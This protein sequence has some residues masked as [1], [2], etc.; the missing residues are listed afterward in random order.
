MMGDF[1]KAQSIMKTARRRQALFGL[2]L[3]ALLGA[4]ACVDMPVRV[5]YPDL[6]LSQPTEGEVVAGLKEALARGVHSA[7][8]ELGRTNGFYAN[9]LVR[10]A[11]PQDLSR[12]ETTLRQ[13]GQG[14][15]VDEFETTLNRA[16]ERAVPRAADIFADAIRQMSVRDAIDLVQGPDDAATRYFQRTTEARLRAAFRP[17]V[18][19]QTQRVGVT[20]SYKTMLDRAGFLRGFISPE[21]QDLDGYVTQ[22]ALDGL[23]TYIAIEEKKIREQPAART[24]ELLRK[25]FGYYAS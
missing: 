13:L 10:I 24:S 3:C 16:A 14:H 8:T 22:K 7:V 11:M 4:A 6:G 25:V 2:L 18:A 9:E 15:Y 21:A 23:F 19:E 17:I 20:S 1:M 12:L 5:E